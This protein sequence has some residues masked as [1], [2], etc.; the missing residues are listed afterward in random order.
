[1]AAIGC[2]AWAVSI[3]TG[4]ATG[5]ERA[6]KP[7]AEKKAAQK[8]PAIEKAPQEKDE[9]AGRLPP[10][11]KDVVDDAQR[12]KIYAIQGE[13]AARLERLRQQLDAL[14]EERDQ[15]IEAVLTPQQRA[16]VEAAREEAQAERKAKKAKE[17]FKF[18]PRK[19]G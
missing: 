1:M 11:Y 17:K 15:R 5:Q 6:K 2:L 9:P 3:P 7:A 18:P 8:K 14:E 10:Y 4:L 12:D 16:K 13:Y 19:A